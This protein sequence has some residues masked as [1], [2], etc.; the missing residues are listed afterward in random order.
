[1]CSKKAQCP[2]GMQQCSNTLEAQTCTTKQQLQVGGAGGRHQRG[3]QA[4]GAPKVYNELPKNLHSATNAQINQ[5]MSWRPVTT[6]PGA[7][8]TPKVCVVAPKSRWHK[9][10]QWE[11]CSEQGSQEPS[12]SQETM[13]NTIMPC[14]NKTIQRIQRP[15]T[16]PRPASA[17][18]QDPAILLGGGHRPGETR[19]Q[20]Q[21]KTPVSASLTAPDAQISQ[22][23]T[24]AAAA[25]QQT[26]T[27]PRA[28]KTQAES[29][30]ITNQ[31]TE[32]PSMQQYAQLQ[33][34]ACSGS[35]TARAAEGQQKRSQNNTATVPCEPS[36]ATTRSTPMK[37]R[38]HD[39]HVENAG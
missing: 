26:Q 38:S 2:K 7:K 16:Q 4:K 35:G 9:N 34:E 30:P 37:G 8:P 19:S 15:K 13:P 10:L 32:D 21:G 1:V 3:D 31:E 12:T 22:R 36:W 27:T 29:Q 11:S 18:Q 28:G 39:L 33:E 24:T 25:K 14:I 20:K 23:S 6:S 5:P 17:A